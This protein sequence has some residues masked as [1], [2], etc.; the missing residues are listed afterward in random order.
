MRSLSKRAFCEGCQFG[1]LFASVSVL[2]TV[3]ILN[4]AW[5][6]SAEGPF[7]FVEV[8]ILDYFLPLFLFMF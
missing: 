8:V 2:S 5:G 7:V 3:Y 1:L 4:V 6:C